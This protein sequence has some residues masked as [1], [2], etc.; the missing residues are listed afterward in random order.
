MTTGVINTFAHGT[1][2]SQGLL[3][4]K[5]DLFRDSSALK[6]GTQPHNLRDTDLGP[7][8]DWINLG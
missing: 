1:E 3:K 7:I 5:D 6:T 2:L 4:V 8:R